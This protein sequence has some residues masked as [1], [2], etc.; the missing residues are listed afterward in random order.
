MLGYLINVLNF[1]CELGVVL[2]KKILISSK[3]SF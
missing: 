3:I 2:M 1:V